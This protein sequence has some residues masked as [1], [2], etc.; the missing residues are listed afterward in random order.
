MD[1]KDKRTQNKKHDG[2]TVR[3]FLHWR[4]SHG[5]APDR[6]NNLEEECKDKLSRKEKYI[7]YERDNPKFRLCTKCGSRSG[8]D[9]TIEGIYKGKKSFKKSK[10]FR[11]KYRLGTSQYMKLAYLDV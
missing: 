9:I 3:E 4:E 2:K 7:A 5:S 11:E 6:K 1:S 8:C 10:F